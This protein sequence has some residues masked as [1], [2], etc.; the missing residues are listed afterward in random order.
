MTT[1]QKSLASTARAWFRTK[2][3]H[4]C[5]PCLEL[6]GRE[7]IYRRTV[8]GDTRMPSFTRSSSAIRSSPQVRFAAA[9]VAINCCKSAGIG[10][11]PRARDFQ[12]HHNRNPCRC[13]RMRVSGFTTV[14]KLR[15]STGDKRDTCGVTGPTRLHLPFQVHRRQG[16]CGEITTDVKDGSEQRPGRSEHDKTDPTRPRQAI[17]S[18]V[19]RTRRKTAKNGAD[20]LF[21]DHTSRKAVSKSRG[22]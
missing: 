19:Q 18:G 16:E 10:G 7:G 15:Q 8:R 12:R 22:G 20:R 2:V 14:S 5:V 6:G 11:R 17:E 21:A 4:V 3:L 9:I 13:Q 1:T